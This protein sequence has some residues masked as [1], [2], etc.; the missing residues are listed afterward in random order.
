VIIFDID[1]FKKINDNLGH[2]VGDIVLR[3]VSDSISHE[4][5]KED[6]FGRYGGEEFLVV[7][8]K[9]LKTS[10]ELAER[11]RSTIENIDFSEYGELRV[12]ASFGISIQ[13]NETSFEELVKNADT[14][15]YHAK[16]N[17]R[18]KVSH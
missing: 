9:D 11:L 7:F 17:G 8:Q 15:L 18:N 4:L 13:N 14:K 16:E 10:V 12:T 6:Y 2:S 5:R 3:Q 1:F